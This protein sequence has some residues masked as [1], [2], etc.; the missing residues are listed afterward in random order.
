[1]R[2]SSPSSAISIDP[3]LEL[4]VSV[5]HSPSVSKS[6]ERSAR[7]TNAR[8]ANQISAARRRRATV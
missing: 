4:T 5:W 1:M 8:M 3:L 6:S 2:R 7:P